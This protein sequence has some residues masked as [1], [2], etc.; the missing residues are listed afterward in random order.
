MWSP[1]FGLPKFVLYASYMDLYFWFTISTIEMARRN[2][3]S[4]WDA[5]MMNLE[6]HNDGLRKENTRLEAAL[7]QEIKEENVVIKI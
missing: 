6:S 3:R 1:S 5:E 4:L 2:E 7:R